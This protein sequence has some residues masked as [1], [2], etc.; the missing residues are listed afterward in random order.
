MSD[1]T[2]PHD[3]L[4]ATGSAPLEAPSSHDHLEIAE[5]S[6][7]GYQ[8]L[9]E[10][11]INEAEHNFRLIV[12][13]DPENN[14]ALVGLGDAARKKGTY[15]DAVEYYKKCLVYHPGNNY[16]LFG[17]ADCYKALNQY[18]KAIEIWEQYLLHD[19]KN[20]T[21][22]TRIADAY[23]KVRDFKKSKAIYLRVLEMETD[24]P[25][26]LIGLGHL[27]YDF[28]EY[29]DAL[30]YWARMVQFQGESVDI[31]VLT[32]IG[33]CYRKL[34][35]FDMGVPYFERALSKEP[36]N[37]YALFGLADCYRGITEPEKSLQYWNRILAKDPKNKVILTRAGDAYRNMGDYEQASYFYSKALDIEFDVYAVLGMATIAR[38][39]GKIS[40][41]IESLHKLVQNDT[42]NYRLYIE[43][44]QCYMATGDRKRAEEILQDYQRLGIRNP[45]VQDLLARI[46]S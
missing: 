40:D 28:K 21:V 6:K 32:S 36:D 35:Q 41:A 1:P 34:K 37:F 9:K 11:R 33:N 45:H 7:K 27:H 43:L 25:Y 12:E 3:E 2:T 39:Q 16:A 30:H 20:I 42:R 5:I 26:A 46:Q 29:R 4:D 44:A 31:R 24:N 17:L 23:R 10:N 19:N 13:E 22:L 14:Y 38:L 8:Y 15:R 18:Q